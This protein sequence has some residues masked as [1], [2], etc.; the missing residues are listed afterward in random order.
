MKR[1]F[2]SIKVNAEV[3]ELEQVHSD[4]A[5]RI[6]CELGIIRQTTNEDSNVGDPDGPELKL[7]QCGG[8]PVEH[9]VEIEALRRVAIE[10]ELIGNLLVDNGDRGAGIQY[11]LQISSRADAALDLDEVA[12]SEPEGEFAVRSEFCQ[13]VLRFGF[14]S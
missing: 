3:G 8:V 10:L 13:A 2:A 7:R 6:L 4:D 5:V 11:E 9:S 1:D 14:G 12:G